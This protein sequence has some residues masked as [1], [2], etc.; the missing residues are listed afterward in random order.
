MK[1]RL[2]FLDIDGVLNNRKSMRAHKV[3]EFEGYTYL[4]QLWLPCVERMN[5]LVEEAE[6]DVILSSAWR[7][8]KPYQA[9][10]RYFQQVC[11]ATFDIVGAT[12]RTFPL[13]DSN[14]E[15]SRRGQEIDKWLTDRQDTRPFVI[16]DD[17]SDMKPHMDRLVRVEHERG[18]LDRHVEEAL[19]L[20]GLAESGHE[21]AH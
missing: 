20:F 6:C 14:R 3:T 10:S 19:R 2:L 16:V 17:D 7:Y 4:S 15:W 21:G 11:G 18:L 9:T 13:D 12:P 8:G 5:R 1:P